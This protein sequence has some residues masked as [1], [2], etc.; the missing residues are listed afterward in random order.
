MDTI[1]LLQVGFLLH[2]PACVGRVTDGEK[3][4]RE[5]E[6]NREIKTYVFSV[7]RRKSHKAMEAKSL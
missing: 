3:R 4:G 5:R 2:Y 7:I 1:Y 6:R